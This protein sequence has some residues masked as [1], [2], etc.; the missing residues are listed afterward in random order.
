MDR[1]SISGN[2]CYNRISPWSANKRRKK[3]Y[4][5]LTK[6]DR[7]RDREGNRQG[8]EHHS[9]GDKEEQGGQSQGGIRAEMRKTEG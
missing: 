8:Q 1:C 3:M 9:A 4:K 7:E 5:Q 2:S 6:E